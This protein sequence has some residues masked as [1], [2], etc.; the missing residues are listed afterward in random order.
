MAEE[1]GNTEEILAQKEVEV[2]T[3][4]EELEAAKKRVED[5][6]DMINRQA[7]EKGEDRKSIKEGEDAISD[8]SKKMLETIAAA[9]SV[10]DELAKAKEELTEL[11]KE[12]PK[13]EETT[14]ISDDEKSVE[15]IE[16]ALTTEEQ[17][18][19]DKCWEDADETT[20]KSIKSDPVLRKQVLIKA[21]EAAQVAKKSDL[22]DWRST[23]AQEKTGEAKPNEEL[24]A[25]MF[26]KMKDS[27]GNIPDAPN[28]GAPRGQVKRRQGSGQQREAGWIENSG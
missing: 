23:P 16:A 9:D 26:N 28:N 10:R 4:A 15:E 18:V 27:A 21:K 22:T 25:K 11:K 1:N 17:A 6:Q 13:K 20:R 5:S 12:G 19:V 2:K 24:L 14:Q 3:L 7:G 8:L